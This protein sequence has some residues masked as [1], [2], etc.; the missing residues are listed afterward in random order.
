MKQIRPR[1][2]FLSSFLYFRYIVKVIKVFF[3]LKKGNLKL[4]FKEQHI[5]YIC[6]KLYF[7]TMILLFYWWY[8]MYFI[9]TFKYI[10]HGKYA[11]LCDRV[12]LNNMHKRSKVIIL[13]SSWIH[14]KKLK[15]KVYNINSVFL[16]ILIINSLQ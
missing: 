10:M 14:V 16:F 8:E 6:W 1:K 4:Y 15:N 5:F 12:I 13:M 2:D 11:L 9:K 3:F 7:N